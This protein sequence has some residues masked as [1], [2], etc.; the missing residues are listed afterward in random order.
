MPHFG[1]Y[2]HNKTWILM[3]WKVLMS[4]VGTYFLQS[5]RGNN[6]MGH[7]KENSTRIFIQ[8]KPWQNKKY[9]KFVVMVTKSV[10]SMVEL[11]CQF[12]Y[13]S[14]QP[15]RPTYNGRYTVW[16][17]NHWSKHTYEPSSKLS[18]QLKFLTKK[19]LLYHN[20][21]KRVSWLGLTPHY[22]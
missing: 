20:K 4:H 9:L 22:D 5:S 18:K 12:Q 14:E 15:R 6:K 13:P 8:L 10:L 2:K 11:L 7:C 1:L 21:S 16:I 3:N 17:S 19:E